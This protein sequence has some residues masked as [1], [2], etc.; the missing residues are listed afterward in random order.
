MIPNINKRTVTL[1]VMDVLLDLKAVHL[2]NVKFKALLEF[3]PMLHR[4]IA[5]S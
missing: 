1:G 4:K 2:L 5:K 3:K